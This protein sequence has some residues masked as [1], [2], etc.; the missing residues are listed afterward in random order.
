MGVQIIGRPYAEAI[1]L[2]LCKALQDATGFHKKVPDLKGI[3]L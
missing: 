1:V 2:K 3:G